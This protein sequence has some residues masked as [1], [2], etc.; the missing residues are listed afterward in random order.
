MFALDLANTGTYD[1]QIKAKSNLT[2][3]AQ[4]PV[5]LIRD[6]IPTVVF[7]FNGTG[8]EWASIEKK[9]MFDNKYAVLQLYFGQNGL[10]AEE[11]RFTLDEPLPV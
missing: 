11:I 6:G 3:L 9:V 8:G 7:T 10:E 2:Q 1:V 5:T 4:I